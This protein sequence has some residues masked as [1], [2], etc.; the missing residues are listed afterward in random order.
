M[1]IN[2][3]EKNRELSIGAQK[4]RDREPEDLG[5]DGRIILKRIL[6]E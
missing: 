2:T 1:V 5:V 4:G 3:G 6:D